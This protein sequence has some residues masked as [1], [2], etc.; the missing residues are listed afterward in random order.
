MRIDV[1][2]FSQQRILRLMF[3]PEIKSSVV[4]SPLSRMY[5]YSL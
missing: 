4:E 5:S 3:L 1:S 2:H